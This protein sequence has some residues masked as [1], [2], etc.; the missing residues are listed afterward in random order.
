M[1]KDFM[2][3]EQI[4][5]SKR[6]ATYDIVHG[7]N[8]KCSEYDILVAK[9]EPKMPLG[10]SSLGCEGVCKDQWRL[11][12]NAVMRRGFKKEGI[13]FAAEQLSAFERPCASEF[14]AK[15]HTFL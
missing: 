11:A 8:G 6:L 9:L 7:R 2:Y 1:A 5:E 3:S 12:V 10:R 14:I 4:I 13:C 15:A